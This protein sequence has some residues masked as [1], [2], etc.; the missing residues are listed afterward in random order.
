AEAG[1]LPSPG[2]A[3]TA[4]LRARIAGSVRP[5]GT[6]RAKAMALVNLDLQQGVGMLVPPVPVGLLIF[7]LVSGELLMLAMVLLFPHAMR[8]VFIGVPCVVVVVL[9]VVV[10][11]VVGAQRAGRNRDRDQKGGTQE[12]RIPETRHDSSPVSC[13]C[14]RRSMR[15]G[16]RR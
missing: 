13:E 5:A 8:L 6:A 9:L 1:T 4:R 11:D 16:L 3:A 2:S 15:A 10:L 7:R 14:N 12:D